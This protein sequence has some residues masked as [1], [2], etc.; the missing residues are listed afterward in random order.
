M[1]LK[2][3]TITKGASVIREIA[4]KEGINLI[5]DESSVEITGNNVGKTTVLKLIDFCLGAN[6]RNI[7]IDPENPKETYNLV[8]DF[9]IQNEILITLCLKEDL[10]IPESNEVVIER[11]F[12]SPV[13]KAIRRINGQHY[14]EEEFEPNLERIFFPDNTSSKPTFRQIIS[15]NIR[16]KDTSI[17]NTLKTL[18]KF[19]SNVEYETLYLFLLGCEFTSGNEKQEILEKIS[20]ELTFKS[21]LQK[22]QTKSAYEAKLAIVEQKYKN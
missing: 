18:D 21:R 4:F 5:V 14:I 13:K 8:K 2:S 10:A 19:T 22:V 7:W 20:R 3:L 9:L 17:S 1:F 6:K 12:L 15:H 11:N 16:Y